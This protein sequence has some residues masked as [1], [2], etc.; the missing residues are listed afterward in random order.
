MQKIMR[1]TLK[2]ISI[3]I[4]LM[5]FMFTSCRSE[6]VESIQTPAEDTLNG[7]VADLMQRTA[8]NDG[9][10]DNIIDNANCVSISFPVTVI[11]NGTEII[12]NSE[13]DLDDI[14]DV[15]DE[16]DDDD[17]TIELIF[18]ITIILSDFTEIVVNNEDELENYTDDCN[19]ENEFDDD[20]ECIDF[21]Y[22]ITANIFNS[23]NEIIDTIIITNDNELHDFIEDIDADDIITLNFPIT[24][25]LFDGTSMTINNLTELATAIENAEDL[26]D[27]DD[28]NDFNDDDCNNCTPSALDNLLTNCSNWTIDKLERNDEDLEDNYTG[29]VF[30]F[31]AD[32][33][34]LAEYNTNQY[35]GTWSSSGS[36]NDIT[37]VIDIPTLP[38]CNNNWILHEIEENPGETN[39]DLRLGDDR[40]RYESTCN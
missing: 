7:N 22:P 29:Y 20:I 4:L 28:D 1:T 21:Q 11:A 25:L 13:E 10:N 34:L 30:N 2:L 12:V 14:E 35:P 37:V 36:G 32:G 15:F 6:E 3:L 26:C 31:M 39:I 24:V 19:G 18:P 38:D 8:L 17:D 23:S 27:E 5:T 33:T 40:L 16:F 9:S